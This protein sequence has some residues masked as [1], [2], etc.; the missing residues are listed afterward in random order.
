M[1]KL[2]K[3][4]SELLDTSKSET[5]QLLTPGKKPTG[6][7]D[8]EPRVSKHRFSDGSTDHEYDWQFR[9]AKGNRMDITL[10]LQKDSEGGKPLMTLSFGKVTSTGDKYYTT[11]G[12]GDLKAIL[13][14]VIKAADWVIGTENVGGRNGLYAISY[15]PSDDKRDRIYQYFIKNYFPNFQLKD[16]PGIVYKTFVNQEYKA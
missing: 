9:N 4:L 1:I 13:A 11:T 10:S 15:T 2:S 16:V 7:G 14:T 6:T 3:I 12:A 5:Y 8:M